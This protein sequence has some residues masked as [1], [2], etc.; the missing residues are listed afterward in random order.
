MQAVKKEILLA[1]DD[2]RHSKHALRYVIRAAQ[3][4]IPDLHFTLF[5]VEGQIS[6]FLK[7][8]AKGANFQARMDLDRAKKDKKKAA[9]TLLERYKAE[10]AGAGIP[11]EHIV[12]QSRPRQTGLAK[13]I[14]EHGEEGL[15]DAIVVGRRGLSGLQ[16][17]F[18]ESVSTS[19]LSHASF[20]PLWLVCGELRHDRFLLALDET[21]L[22]YRAADH[23]AFMLYGNP[24]AEVTFFHVCSG[25]E[26][27][28]PQ[29]FYHA[30]ER[31]EKAGIAAGRINQKLCGDS[32]PGKAILNE[33]STGKY[34]TLIM[35]REGGSGGF[36]Q[37]S[38]S[39]EVLAGMDAG[40]VWLV[41]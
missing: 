14:V 22:S 27:H 6:G 26:R 36:F 18:S 13:A 30:I 33:F 1:L 21:D 10:M 8:E 4:T 24:Q 23:L 11:E 41:F 12:I 35:G 3:L 7:E 16:R 40:A 17:F 38:I 9:K 25:P 32:R 20:I 37:S 5:H 15:Y 29:N 31:L 39:D 19:L 34:G 2:S 28:V